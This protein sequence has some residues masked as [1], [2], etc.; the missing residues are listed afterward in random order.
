M[1]DFYFGNVSDNGKAG[2]YSLS[3][4]RLNTLAGLG[5]E[6]QS[7]TAQLN[8]LLTKAD[9]HVIVNDGTSYPDFHTL[10]NHIESE[11]ISMI[12][13][14]A[15]TDINESVNATLACNIYLAEGVLHVRP[16]WCGYKEIRADEIIDTLLVP[17]FLLNLNSKTVINDRE[18]QKLATDPAEAVHQIFALSKY[19]RQPRQ[20][21][22]VTDVSFAQSVAEN[23]Y[24]GESAYREYEKL[25][26]ENRNKSW[27]S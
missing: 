27:A 12:E 8:R 22:Y 19:P 24:F 14:E 20:T 11:A 18:K 21:T 2:E 1:D 26:T 25:R 13:L 7:F 16:H 3:L 9:C 15:R 10:I 5:V 4:N 17:L 23:G 6:K